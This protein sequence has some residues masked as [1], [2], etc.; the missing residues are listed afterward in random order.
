M[1]LK[2][3]SVYTLLLAV[4]CVILAGI[5]AMKVANPPQPG[6][7]KSVPTADLTLPD[8]VQPTSSNEFTLP[9]M[10]AYSEIIERPLFLSSR[11]PPEEPKIVEQKQPGDDAS[12]TLLGVAVTPERTMALLQTDKA[13]KV[14][15]V[16]IGEEV[17]GWRLEAVRVDGVTLRRDETVRNVPLLR[18]TGPTAGINRRAVPPKNN[19]SVAERQVPVQAEKEGKD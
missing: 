19:E 12:F 6:Q 16:G 11:R 14:A 4:I 17:N 2:P 9:P 10:D 8:N 15:R 5:V 13:G 1:G 18:K 7:P 3:A